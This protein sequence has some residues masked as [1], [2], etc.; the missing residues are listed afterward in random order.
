MTAKC[1]TVKASFCVHHG[2]GLGIVSQMKT[3]VDFSEGSLMLFLTI[4][5]NSKGVAHDVP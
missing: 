5:G 2:T 4:P 1:K 3:F